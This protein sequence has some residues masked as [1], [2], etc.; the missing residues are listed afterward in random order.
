MRFLLR[1]SL[2]FKMLQIEAIAQG[3]TVCTFLLALHLK[4]VA[5]GNWATVNVKPCYLYSSLTNSTTVC[6]EFNLQIYF[7]PLRSLGQAKNI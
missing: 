4:T 1:Q 7:H 6:P 2:K 5:L 3:A